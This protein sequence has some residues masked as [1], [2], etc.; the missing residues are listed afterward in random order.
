MNESPLTGYGCFNMRDGKAGGGGGGEGG[1][2][3]EMQK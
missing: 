1:G 2:L 3:V